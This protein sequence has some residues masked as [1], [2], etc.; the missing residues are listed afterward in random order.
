MG[1][2][3]LKE[4][5]TL[6]ILLQKEKMNDRVFYLPEHA[7]FREW[8]EKR[9][10]KTL[11]AE[12]S[13]YPHQRK[14]VSYM[15]ES[16]PYRGILLYHGL[17]VG[18]S[19][20]AIEI[21][22]A[23]PSRPVVLF[24]PASLRVNFEGELKKAGY[25]HAKGI[26]YVNYNGI[27]NNNIHT[28]VP[29]LDDKLVII[30]EVHNFISRVAGKGDVG[31]QVY[32]KI[33]DAKN[34]RIVCLSGT[35]LI[36]RPFELGLL[37]N[38]M[39]GVQ[40][41]IL[42]PK[43]TEQARLAALKCKH[44]LR[45]E[46]VN[47]TLEIEM[48]PPGFV[49]KEAGILVAA[50]SPT[51]TMEEVIDLCGLAGANKEVKSRIPFPREE[52]PFDELYVDYDGCRPKDPN[53]FM[54]KV[55]G[56]VSYFENYD[57]KTYPKKER[58]KI[59]K[60]EMKDRQLS[61]YNDVRYNEI[62][63][64]NNALKF[65]RAG[66][67][68]NA[69]KDQ[70]MS[71]SKYRIFSRAL[72]NFA[73]PDSIHRPVPSEKILVE[74]EIADQDEL[75]DAV[76]NKDATYED[77]VRACLQSL[78]RES[79][80]YLVPEA[81]EKLGPKI[82]AILKNVEA[83]PGSCL[84]YSVFR[85]VEG[86]KIMAMTLEQ[87]GYAELKVEHD[88]KTDTWRFVNLLKFKRSKHPMFVVFTEEKEQTRILMNV[89]NGEYGLLPPELQGEL[90]DADV[91]EKDSLEPTS[92]EIRKGGFVK[93]LLITQSG[94]E[95][96]SL[97]N[98][99][100]VHL[101]EPHWNM[102]RIDQVIG[103][104]VRANS[105]AAMLPEDRVVETFLYEMTFGKGKEKDI[106]RVAINAR[107]DGLSSDGFVYR[108]AQ[109]KKE[110]TDRFLLLLQTASLEAAATSQ[111]RQTTEVRD[112]TRRL[113][114]LPI[115]IYEKTIYYR[116]NPNSKEQEEIKAMMADAHVFETG[117]T[118]TYA[119]EGKESKKPLYAIKLDPLD[120]SR[121]FE[122]PDGDIKMVAVTKK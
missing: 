30:D 81:L 106:Q 114:K 58:L 51:P 2:N 70:L 35:P 55:N 22:K 104:A 103:R 69:A 49:R 96:V 47:N 67:G 4:K 74:R 20:S 121:I 38:L 33:Q 9:W 83:A 85:N 18:K 84:I 111:Q 77:K 23:N 82:G 10:A 8:L 87:A 107:D 19:R 59:I 25:T 44:V 100:Q 57:L 92:Y 56:M 41:V 119:Y 11:K 73:F 78:K 116:A 48:C 122:T 42:F 105:H 79:G 94:S 61:E 43:K 39:S 24:L 6:Y 13:L 27:M 120:H 5:L 21:M 97:K 3:E 53:G 28:K 80:T 86:I 17:G 75:P 62:K 90:R 113:V 71:G 108:I 34:I 99:R 52:A 12:S 60:L 95:G 29:P 112:T 65:D 37:A 31:K 14:V 102:V 98:T 72:C 89:F 46:L 110:L 91:I 36:N 7:G 64:E 118:W 15:S 50:K 101:L 40:T 1:F 115:P 63:K 66:S 93:A 45:A 54:A 109:R 88:K 117:E 76:S 68:S 26:E 16:T 32:Q